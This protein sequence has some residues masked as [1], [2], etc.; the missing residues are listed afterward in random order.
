MTIPPG[1]GQGE[2]V[3]WVESPLQLLSAIEAHTAGQLGARTRAWPRLV[4]AGMAEFLIAF[5][6]VP[7]PEGFSIDRPEPGRH[8]LRDR[9]VAA[10]GIGDA[11]SGR[12]QRDMLAGTGDTRLVLLDDGLITRTA[13]R[14]LAEPG[15]QPLVRDSAAFHLGRQLLGARARQQL[16]RA[17]G[18]GRLSLFTAMALAPEHIRALEEAGARITSHSFPWLASLPVT[19]QFPEPNIVIGSAMVADRL[20]P[21]DRYREWV[22]SI[23]KIAPTRYFPHRRTHARLLDELRAH[24]A[25]TVEETGLPV[26]LRLRGLSSGQHVYCLPT[27]ALQ[28]LGLL[29]RAAGVTLHPRPVPDSWWLPQVP[30]AER[31]YL[32]SFTENNGGLRP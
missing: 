4:G 18:R 3:A 13:V 26:E 14:R 28:S 30:A 29:L 7:L 23:A 21:E 31:S 10:F 6:G 12:V 24:P 8:P 32:N 5:E 17:A 19:E 27:S 9:R 11:F 25:I 15:W 20:I 22:L 2:A 1:S 16:L